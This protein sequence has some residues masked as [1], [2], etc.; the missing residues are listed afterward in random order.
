MR[1][2]VERGLLIGREVGRVIMILFQQSSVLTYS[3]AYKAVGTWACPY[4]FGRE[5]ETP[6]Q[7]QF[8]RDVVQFI[9]AAYHARAVY[10]LVAKS[11][12]WLGRDTN[13]RW[14]RRFG[15]AISAKF[16][17]PSSD[18]C[19]GEEATRLRLCVEEPIGFSSD[20]KQEFTVDFDVP[21]VLVAAMNSRLVATMEQRV[22]AFFLLP[23]AFCGFL[24]PAGFFGDGAPTTSARVCFLVMQ[25]VAWLILYKDIPNRS[26]NCEFYSADD[27]EDA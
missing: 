6:D 10:W 22:G 11:W 23:L 24:G 17:S 16:T 18:E 15:S 20:W 12:R 27:T 9:G 2:G 3:C 21:R 7:Q 1:N 26:I 14:S 25:M 8:D 19:R 4:K 13:S 5:W